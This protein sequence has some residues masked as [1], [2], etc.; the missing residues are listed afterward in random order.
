MSWLSKGWKE[1]ERAVKKLTKQIDADDFADQIILEAQ[2]AL[3]KLIER[4][5]LPLVKEAERLL[6]EPKSGP[7]KFAW[8]ETE[9]KQIYK[10]F[11]RAGRDLF[12]TFLIERAVIL[13]KQGR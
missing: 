12:I 5:A 9:L 6:T 13:M 10:E 7:Q 2:H 3:D 1:I 8:V 11:N 4:I